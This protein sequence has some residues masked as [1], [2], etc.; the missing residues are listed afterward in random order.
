MR[1]ITIARVRPRPPWR[2]HTAT[3]AAL[4]LGTLGLAGGALLAGAGS[5]DA[6]SCPAATAT[7]VTF[8]YTGAAQTWTVPAGVTQATFRL[9][10]A[11]GGGNGS[12][13]GN[14]GHGAEV[15]GNLAVTPGTVLQVDVGQAGQ[16]LGDTGTGNAFGGGGKGGSDAGGGGGA[17]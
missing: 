10:G 8:C 14:G 12:D 17:S 16:Y 9:Y 4:A 15:T 3:M 13:S 6:A 11:N 1:G 7:S 2:K 5:A